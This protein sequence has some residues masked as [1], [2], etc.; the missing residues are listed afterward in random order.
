MNKEIATLNLE[1]PDGL[2]MPQRVW[3]ILSTILAIGMSCLDVNIVNVALPSLAKEFSMSPTNTI[4]IVNAYQLAIVVSL[5][6]FSS[7]GDIYGF[8]KVYLSG[9]FVFT[10]SS[11]FCALSSSFWIL[12]IARMC[13]GLGASALTSVNQGQ[14]RTIYPRKH[15]GRGM[16]INAMAVSVSA[17]AGPSIASAILS[18]ATWQWLFVVNIPLGIIALVFGYKY[19]P[20][21]EYRIKEKFDK[22][23]AL[24]N[25]LTFGLLI[26]SLDG[27]AHHENTRY[28]ALQLIA[29]VFVALYY[30][31]RERQREAP[32]LPV[33]L[34]RIPILS[35]SVFTSICSF[36][37]QMLGMVSL[38]FF[39]QNSM[40]LSIVE[41]GLLLTP[42]P[43]ATLVAAP[44]A[45]Y[46]VERVHPGLLGCVGMI[47]F[48]VGM[49]MMTLLPQNPS[50]IDIVWR[51]MLCGIGFGLFQTP[52]NNVIVTSSP[53]NRGGRASGMIGTARLLGQTLGTTFVA[54]IFSLVASHTEASIYCLYLGTSFALLAAFVSPL[55]LGMHWSK[56][57]KKRAK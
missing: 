9:I 36:A 21:K 14:L 37:A 42:W 45:G 43:L 28:I 56:K 16:G 55:R 11:L 32:L 5:L 53:V 20:R 49:Y 48:A 38:P 13:Q 3:A 39:F 18:V 35:M 44:L 46:L 47:S 19:L 40:H 57:D 10:L 52:N 25:A 2:P 29:L 12:V 24:A 50:D 1:Q 17:V 7:L 27:F 22:L 8:R 31:H 54:F 34:L 26:Y 4:W 15:L 30:W 51:L 6:A 23:G 33:D 41:T